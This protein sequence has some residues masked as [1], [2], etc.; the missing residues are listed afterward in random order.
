MELYL[1]TSEEKKDYIEQYPVL[2]C[3]NSI[4]I[5]YDDYMSIKCKKIAGTCTY[6]NSL[7]NEYL[8][9]KILNEK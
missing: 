3:E 1:I 6:R 9:C 8:N 5:L 4:G 7:N 2:K